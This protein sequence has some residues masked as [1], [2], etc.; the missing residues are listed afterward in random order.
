[1]FCMKINKKIGNEGDLTRTG[2]AFISNFVNKLR[3]L[4]KKWIK[5]KTNMPMQGAT[6]RGGVFYNFFLVFKKK[7]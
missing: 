1:M 7:L 5:Y 6:L 2:F 3:N 4:K